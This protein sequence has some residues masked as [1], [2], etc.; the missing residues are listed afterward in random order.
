MRVT[1]MNCNKKKI[2]FFLTTLRNCGPTN[3]VFNLIKS[4]DPKEFDIMLIAIRE[5]ND[6]YAD[7]IKK[8]CNLGIHY[9]GKKQKNNLIKLS[10]KL[11]IIHSH[12][13]FPDRLLSSINSKTIKKITTI[14]CEF[15]PD[16]CQ[17]FGFFK[18]IIASLL[19]LYFLNMGKF[20]KIIGCSASVK[21]HLE[22]F[23]INRKI[24]SFINNGVDQSKFFKLPT[25]SKND[26]RK[27]DFPGR[28]YI[29]IYSGR[30]IRRKRVPELIAKFNRVFNDR[31][32]VL[33]I[34]IGDGEELEK[35][36]Q[37]AK[38][39]ISFLGHVD[40]PEYYY[41]I[42][43]FIVSMSNAEGY[44]MSIL[45]A[46]SCGCYAFLS[47]NKSHL[48]FIQ[49]NPNLAVLIDNLSEDLIF[50]INKTK[51]MDTKKLSSTIMAESYAFIYKEGVK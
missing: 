31:Q 11:D 19:H 42:S 28:D 45:E 35:C 21:S 47:N 25:E 38:Q 3:M 14:H 27:K 20:D 17:E 4:L 37:L 43:D 41:K 2:G 36:K 10:S 51:N 1:S 34:I 29:F 5:I 9:L 23:L 24:L 16:Y 39:N 22:K 48:E 44:P 13:F 33:L 32:D 26:I 18:G 30:L 7:N 8:Y 12:G 15:F 40:N 50:S 46:V 49:N 6:G